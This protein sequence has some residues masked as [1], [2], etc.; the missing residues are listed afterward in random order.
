MVYRFGPFELDDELFQL[1]RGGAVVPLQPRVF[2]LLLFLIRKRDVVVTRA[3][4]LEHVWGGTVVTKD[5]VAQAVMALRKG[6]GDDGESPTYVE[7][8]RARGYRFVAPL[9]GATT[10]PPS[11]S[12]V[13]A[14]IAIEAKVAKVVRRVDKGG[15]VVLVSGEPG[16]GRTRFVTEVAG[17]VP[18]SIVVRCA[19]DGAP[20][21]WFVREVLREL[22]A[23]GAAEETGVLADLATGSFDTLSLEVPAAR[24]AFADTFLDALVRHAG[25]APLLLVAD[26]LHEAD[27]TTLALVELLA[28]RLPTTPIVLCASYARSASHARGFHALLGAL[29]HEP[30]VLIV[31]LEPF[32]RDDVAAYLEAIT[33]RELSGELVDR[34]FQKTRG[35]ALLLTQL[36][37]RESVE[38]LHTSV[39]TASL[40]DVDTLR[41]AIFRQL[42]T[43][44]AEVQRVLTMAAVFGATFAVAPLATAAGLDNAETLGALDTATRA[45]ILRRATPTTYQFLYPLVR[46]VLHETLAG[47]DRAELHARAARALEPH[48]VE[49]AGYEQVGAL[50]KH[51]V[52]AAAVGDVDAALD[53]S[54]KACE[55][56]AKGGD[57][58]A[59]S[60][61]AEAGLAASTFAPTPATQK[62]ARL[63]SFTER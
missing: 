47:R 22:R 21:L 36:A 37:A 30:S 42:R 59:A 49:G 45:G 57:R 50:A 12:D 27:E 13:S 25:G 9:L 48:V 56:A 32:T 19:V 6:L 16:V 24:F 4:L 1:R 31:P 43:L 28:P 61:Y 38:W 46:D 10:A 60:R 35:N 34:I 63:R 51:F 62:V 40:V 26:D 44:D 14:L 18:R 58:V 55:L 20:K 23:R 11:T 5:A 7:T 54:L 41:D 29:T 8:V 3:E 53:W 52:E 33:K 15:G 39:K 17:R 2:D